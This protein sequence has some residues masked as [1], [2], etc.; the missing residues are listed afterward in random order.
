MSGAQEQRR[1]DHIKSAEA[2]LDSRLIPY[3]ARQT[4]LRESIAQS[5]S[6]TAELQQQL[7]AVTAEIGRIMEG[8][9]WWRLY[10]KD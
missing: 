9:L 1:E 10:E 8:S 4:Q 3:R 6:Q 7:D 5:Q 2:D